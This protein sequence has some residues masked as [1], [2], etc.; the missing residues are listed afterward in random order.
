MTDDPKALPSIAES[1]LP[2]GPGETVRLISA[3][4]IGEAQA[5]M[6]FLETHVTPLHSAGVP[7]VVEG[8]G[9]TPLLSI[10][11]EVR[12]GNDRPFIVLVVS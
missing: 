5:L 9:G 6:R 2:P 3:A 12:S 7:I 8:P 1:L 11:I 4:L 10:R